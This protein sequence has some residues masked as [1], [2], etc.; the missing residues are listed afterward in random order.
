PRI[1]I[2]RFELRH[3]AQR[4]PGVFGPVSPR[5]LTR[6]SRQPLS[7]CKVCGNDACTSR[8]AN[9][10]SANLFGTNTPAHALSEV[11]SSRTRV[12]RQVRNPAA[13]SGEIV[14]PVTLRF[15]DD[16]LIPNNPTLPLLI[17]RGAIRLVGSDPAR[18]IEQVFS[19]NHWGDMWRNGIF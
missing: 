11:T 14:A 10:N 17:Y 13:I 16:G 7:V 15:A 5:G 19:G 1:A 9:L 6:P 3:R 2:R 4:P 12:M 18:V 8:T